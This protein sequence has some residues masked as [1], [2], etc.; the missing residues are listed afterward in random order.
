VLGEIMDS[1]KKVSDIVAEIAA[2]SEEQAAG[3]EQV[4]DAV[5]RMDETTQQNAALV[6]EAAAAAKAMEQQAQMLLKE[7][8]FFRSRT[9]SLRTTTAAPERKVRPVAAQP[10]ARSVASQAKPIAA[11]APRPLAKASGDDS[12]WQE[13]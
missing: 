12:V 2:A 9:G 7:I 5:T 3:I 8:S 10:A 11:L 13:F 1:V 6:E 4:N